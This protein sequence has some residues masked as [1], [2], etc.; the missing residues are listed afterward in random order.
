MCQEVNDYIKQFLLPKIKRSNSI[1]NWGKEIF[2]RFSPHLLI[3]FDIKLAVSFIFLILL[4][5]GSVQWYKISSYTWKIDRSFFDVNNC[6]TVHQWNFNGLHNLIIN[7]KCNF[8]AFL[9]IMHVIIGNKNS[10][11]YD[12]D[13]LFFRCLL[14]AD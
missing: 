9:L 8:I 11:K 5:V 10:M 3:H 13:P 6:W 4:Q 1:I 2:L 12:G 14:H 7:K